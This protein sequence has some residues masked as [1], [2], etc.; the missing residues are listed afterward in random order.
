MDLKNF[1]PYRGPPGT[2]GRHGF[3]S[4]VCAAQAHIDLMVAAAADR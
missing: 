2:A 1:Q 3:S 4:T